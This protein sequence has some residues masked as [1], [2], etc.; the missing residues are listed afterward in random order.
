M[1][2]DSRHGGAG[3]R[4]AGSKLTAPIAQ[5]ARRR[6]PASEFRGACADG[7]DVFPFGLSG[8]E[9][10]C[11]AQALNTPDKLKEDRR[12]IS[13]IIELAFSSRF[14]GIHDLSVEPS[15]RP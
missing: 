3:E 2:N 10:G 8:V 1:R 7:V 15:S 4:G 13:V 5:A 14:Y 9:K 12:K 6:A 11:E